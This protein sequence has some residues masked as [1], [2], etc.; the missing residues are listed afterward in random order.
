MRGFEQIT[1]LGSLGRKPETQANVGVKGS[2]IAKLSVAVGSKDKHG[3]PRTTWYTVNA[4]DSI[5]E[6]CAQYLDKGSQ[7]LVVGVPRIVS[8]VG[9]DG[10][11]RTRLEVQA[12]SVT[13]VGSKRSEPLAAA[14]A[15]KAEGAPEAVPASLRAP[16]GK[17]VAK[18]TDDDFVGLDDDEPLDRMMDEL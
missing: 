5:G 9:D 2:F 7:I 10:K 1:I 3:N 4:W 18:E 13:F 16:S 17:V 15:P 12:Q 6:A 8:W 14:A 11:H